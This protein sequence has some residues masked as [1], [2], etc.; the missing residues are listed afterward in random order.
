[1]NDA[2]IMNELKILHGRCSDLTQAHNVMQQMLSDSLLKIRAYENIINRSWFLTRWLSQRKILTEI[3][4][5][6]VV[7][8]MMYKAQEGR[9]SR[10]LEQAQQ[11]KTEEKNKLINDKRVAKNEKN[12][13]RKNKNGE[14]NGK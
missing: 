14:T 13:L 5:V 10:A 8:D 11:I 2:T 12:F 4:R 1:M 9:D 7:E 6:N 3:A